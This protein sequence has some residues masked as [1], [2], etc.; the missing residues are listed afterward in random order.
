LNS[1][2]NKQWGYL[3]RLLLLPV[4]IAYFFS[5]E[6]FARYLYPNKDKEINITGDWDLDLEQN[7]PK[8][9]PAI[10]N[11]KPLFYQLKLNVENGQEVETSG[12]ISLGYEGK[13][14]WTIHANDKHWTAILKN[15]G[16]ITMRGENRSIIK[17]WNNN[18]GNGTLRILKEV[19]TDNFENGSSSYNQATLEIGNGN[20]SGTFKVANQFTNSGKTNVNNG[21]F[22]AGSILNKNEL[23]INNGGEIIVQNEFK[24]EGNIEINEGKVSSNT[25]IKN[26]FGKT[27]NLKN[28]S[29]V[30][31][32]LNNTGKITLSN[33]S[34]ITSKQN[35]LNNGD[36]NS[37]DSNSSITSE[38][39][40]TNTGKINFSGIITS[41]QNLL[42]NG[43]ATIKNSNNIQVDGELINN[44][45]MES[46][47][48][49]TVGKL[50][51]TGG[52]IKINQN[53]TA[54]IKGNL[55]NTGTIENKGTIRV[56]KDNA[57][58]K[59]YKNDKG[60]TLKV[61]GNGTK[62]EGEFKN[63][64]GSTLVVG[65]GDNETSLSL[66]DSSTEFNNAGK[67]D[68]NK[69]SKVISGK[70]FKNDTNG[71]IT[72][73]NGGTLDSSGKKIT[74]AGTIKLSGNTDQSKILAENLDNTNKLS[75]NERS[76]VEI[77]D[78]LTNSGTINLNGQSGSGIST[79]KMENNGTVIASS[80]TIN[81]TES[82]TNNTGNDFKV[83]NTGKI[84]MLGGNFKNQGNASFSGN[85]E[86]RVKNFENQGNA[87]FSGNSDT[88]I[89]ETVK[90]N[91]GI[92]QINSTKKFE[93]H[94][95]L[96]N[97]AI[98][99]ANG[100]LEIAKDLSNSDNGQ[101]KLKSNSNTQISGNVNNDTG[102]FNLYGKL[103]IGSDNLST[104]GGNL[105]NFE[106]STFN[107][108]TG[109][110][111]NIR[112]LFKNE[113]Q[114]SISGQVTA[115]DFE[116]QGNANTHIKNG[117]NM[118]VKNQLTNNN[119]LLVGEENS[120]D[121]D[122]LLKTNDLMNSRI[123]SINNRKSKVEILNNLT[124][125]AGAKIT[126][127]GIINLHGN[128][129]N[130]AD[131]N[132]SEGTLNM[133]NSAKNDTDHTEILKI[134]KISGWGT[135]TKKING[136][137]NIVRGFVKYE[138]SDEFHF[139]GNSTVSIGGSEADTATFKIR[140]SANLNGSL[141][142]HR[143]GNLRIEGEATIGN[144]KIY[145]GGYLQIVGDIN[146]HQENIINDGILHLT[147]A[148]ADTDPE[149]A[150]TRKIESDKLFID[151]KNSNKGSIIFGGT[152]NSK[153]IN[154]SGT[155]HAPELTLNM[156]GDLYN[157][158]FQE[159]F[160]HTEPKMKNDKSILS[161]RL[162][163]LGQ[164]Y[165]NFQVL[166]D[167]QKSQ[168][169]MAQ[170]SGELD[171][172][173]GFSYDAKFYLGA[174]IEYA[175]NTG[176]VSDGKTIYNSG[177]MIFNGNNRINNTKFKNIGG[178]VMLRGVSDGAESQSHNYEDLLKNLN[179]TDGMLVFNSKSNAIT[180]IKVNRLEAM[181]EDGKYKLSG[182][183]LVQNGNFEFYAN[184]SDNNA[185]DK[186]NLHVDDVYIARSA[187]L[188]IRN[189]YLTQTEG[190]VFYN[191]GTMEITNATST[192][193]RSVIDMTNGEFI[194]HGDININNESK[195]TINAKTFIIGMGTN[196]ISEVIDDADCDNIDSDCV[197]QRLEV[198]KKRYNPNQT[199]DQL[200]KLYV[201]KQSNGKYRTSFTSRLR[202]GGHTDINQAGDLSIEVTK[203]V[204]NY[205][206]ISVGSDENGT[207][208]LT[209]PKQ[210]GSLSI[211]SG[212]GTLDNY[213][214]VELVTETDNLTLKDLNNYNEIRVIGAE[215]D[216]K[217]FDILTDKIKNKP[218]KKTNVYVKILKGKV[219]Q[220]DGGAPNRLG[221]NIDSRV[222]KV[223]DG[224]IKSHDTILEVGGGTNHATLNTGNSIISN[225]LDIKENKLYGNGRI[226]VKH[227]G[228]LNIDAAKED[229]SHNPIN[230]IIS[231]LASAKEYANEGEI[232]IKNGNVHISPIEKNNNGEITKLHLHRD[233]Y[234]KGTL[235]ISNDSTLHLYGNLYNKWTDDKTSATYQGN[236][237]NN[238]GKLYVHGG[239][240]VD[241][242]VK[243]HGYGDNS[244]RKITGTMVIDDG[245]VQSENGDLF[246]NAGT[247]EI[248]E[249]GILKI[250]KISHSDTGNIKNNGRIAVVGKYHIS[251]IT[252]VGWG[253]DANTANKGS[254]NLMNEKEN[255]GPAAKFKL[256]QNTFYNGESG[257]SDINEKTK[258][259]FEGNTHTTSNKIENYGSMFFYAK[260][261]AVI[262]ELSMYNTNES[263]LYINSSLSVGNAAASN[264][265]YDI[266]VKNN[267]SKGH[268]IFGAES[269]SNDVFKVNGLYN[270]SVNKNTGKFEI[271]NGTVNSENDMYNE[272]DT[273]FGINSGLK[274]NNHKY[275]QTAGSI[276]L[277]ISGTKNNGDALINGR[278]ITLQNIGS[279]NVNTT[280]L[281]HL[282]NVGKNS[283]VKIASATN[284]LNENMSTSV[285][286]LKVNGENTAIEM[287]V[288]REGNDLYAQFTI[289]DS[290]SKRFGNGK[291]RNEIYVANFLL[292][293]LKNQQ[294]KD[295][296][297]GNTVEEFLLNRA[298]Q[299]DLDRILNQLTLR[300]AE[301]PIYM[302]SKNISQ[303]N[304]K[305]V[306]N[307]A[308][309][310]LVP[311]HFGT[312]NFMNTQEEQKSTT[313]K[314]ELAYIANRYNS[315]IDKD[316]MSTIE[317]K[318]YNKLQS[319]DKSITDESSN[320][321]IN[322][323]S[324]MWIDLINS[325]YTKRATT[326]FSD[327]SAKTNGFVVGLEQ[328]IIK[329]TKGQTNPGNIY[330]YGLAIGISQSKS[331]DKK[332]IKQDTFYDIASN[333][334]NMAVYGSIIRKKSSITGIGSYN[335][336]SFVQDR[337]IVLNISGVHHTATANAKYKSNV[338]SLYGEYKYSLYSNFHIKGFTNYSV[339][340]Q[341]SFEETAAGV[342]AL[343]VKTKIYNDA[344][345]G[346][347][348]EYAEYFLTRREEV[349]IIPHFGVSSTISLIK[350]PIDLDTYF[351]SIGSSSTFKTLS[352]D[353]SKSAYSFNTGLS[354]GKIVGRPLIGRFNYTLDVFDNG[355]SNTF[356][357]RVSKA[358]N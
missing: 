61:V 49:I 245:F 180:D 148:P 349:V 236:I 65:D 234:N 32:G 229:A 124:N 34:I 42:N 346:Y 80:G 30:T 13:D 204:V 22:Q 135:S 107:S 322:K 46:N 201:H 266:V 55:T 37:T 138:D 60:G 68:I 271:V 35:L 141:T 64:D 183:L 324:S 315:I 164:Q 66:N 343:G 319:K 295:D 176:I 218:T 161:N 150:A 269:Q 350:E 190:K 275:E 142:I 351:M 115:K 88:A 157:G 123:L 270:S 336:S 5:N 345:V 330:K 93:I 52:T 284:S 114:A 194:N 316:N 313:L 38:K 221:M 172:N 17:D 209:G 130:N 169:L 50:T 200:K 355:I 185:F 70:D 33:N 323:S 59:G 265:N 264:D 256:S 250:T 99:Q 223:N 219:A 297:L 102:N 352:E 197:N 357:V 167:W 120:T 235:K 314:S 132:N 152:T 187:T 312:L 10:G 304:S 159:N 294:I 252:N 2:F 296:I 147:K 71:D 26:K 18:T 274:L 110:S 154:G 7:Q 287:R 173:D 58:I 317:E 353:R 82:I 198:F 238:G 106:D 211:D 15:N 279:F 134:T 160:D 69:K 267:I 105:T 186:S 260:S 86:I 8:Y 305:I 133:F 240:T 139:D 308:K 261:K 137:F 67:I 54:T 325:K 333:N 36:I 288:F 310:N 247:I 196:N 331:S 278:D 85:S 104:P 72:V 51:N 27:I 127:K 289:P 89:A 108:Y 356:S 23:K 263:K 101:I 321:K 177:Y 6:V 215:N 116:N 224:D 307:I 140:N 339:T 300:T 192:E 182:K 149:T 56:Q 57:I 332:D 276:T 53:E 244:S 203:T 272:G 280:K 298:T 31:E 205:G 162:L 174:N 243:I 39:D 44:G 318:I 48:E 128:L 143:Y 62:I 206:I 258:L 191:A 98:F 216:E 281:L 195:A 73:N 14:G 213:G 28:G 175:K 189:A 338:L 251:D 181:E 337:N 151:H 237:I 184:V 19:S 225:F 156:S 109:S 97:K 77:S 212:N 20:K 230:T 87:S 358:L 118:F 40:I 163:Q 282:L 202:I 24:N 293:A 94:E 290:I 246:Y 119:I 306:E 129:T 1:K 90:N 228:T 112:D 311:I 144:K 92:F 320:H 74:N 328:N 329:N 292:K 158:N 277:N 241:K 344:N 12:N 153:E 111:L 334:I 47:K 188:A 168:I 4:F 78:M 155:I 125:N 25:Q 222:L 259:T 3:L 16:T 113:G 255:V 214:L 257:N 9:K 171:K 342:P 122:T 207:G 231:G 249:N 146:G 178:V 286:T 126:N 291:K 79:K 335:L 327:Y 348:F 254:L 220:G 242:A 29:I 341:D 226:H 84:N 354:I 301:A 21:K 136:N 81:A 326:N 95:N 45:L 248:K 302:M 193:D 121:A 299:D 63:S 239:Q 340:K 166:K 303:F 76:S 273:I 91:S 41:K 131:I 170:I 217:R 208:S 96:E 199:D 233:F 11:P 210:G 179:N 75:I 232:N 103:K 268:L 165:S 283:R 83:E 100:S 227:N 145:N 262:N 117:G 253:G 347:G 43:D 309:D 285:H